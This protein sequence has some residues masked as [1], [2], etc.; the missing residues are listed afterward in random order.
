MRSVEV[1]KKDGRNQFVVHSVSGNERN[2]LFINRGGESFVDASAFSGANSKADSR[3]VAYSDLNHDGFQDL[4]VIN[5]NNPHIEVFA[6]Q[7]SNQA[8]GNFIAVK[9]QGGNKSGMP[10]DEWSNRDGIGAVVSIHAAGKT[11][12]RE[13][14]CGEGF[15]AQNSNTI[16]FGIGDSTN[17]DLVQIQWP[18]GKAQSIKNIG[19]GQVVEFDETEPQPNTQAWADGFQF[20]PPNRKG[21]FAFENLI[22]DKDHQLRVFTTL[23]TSCPNC[24][25][26][27]S[28]MGHLS[29]NT[30]DLP[31]AFFA[32]LTD[33]SD[34]AEA[35]E[36]FKNQQNPSYQILA[37]MNAADRIAVKQFVTTSMGAGVSPCYMITDVT[38]NLLYLETEMP[39]LSDVRRYLYE[40]TK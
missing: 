17:V 29:N 27:V 22:P 6:N 7:F 13:L 39:T 8:G 28:R 3:C 31:V 30:M 12:S 20:S 10:S 26:S 21:T 23:E 15:A 25:S 11:R 14:R 38:G 32:L 9:L 33:E 35:I 18:S 36:E 5:A 2:K 37:K 24:R 16:I 4:V 34:S 1:V 40:S 19:A